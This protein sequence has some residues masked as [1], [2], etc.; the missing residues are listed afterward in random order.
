MTKM[1]ESEEVNILIITLRAAQAWILREDGR[2]PSREE[3]VRNMI[4]MLARD[5][6]RLMRL[7][8]DHEFNYLIKMM[9]RLKE[10][11]DT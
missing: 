4:E 11:D 2:L 1:S 9:G 7:F 5:D 3:L 8:S 10:G 6:D